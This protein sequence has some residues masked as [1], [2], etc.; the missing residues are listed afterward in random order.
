MWQTPSIQFSIHIFGAQE[1]Q[2]PVPGLDGTADPNIV[3]RT[4]VVCEVEVTITAGGAVVAMSV[5]TNS[6]LED[7]DNI[8]NIDTEC[9]SR[10]NIALGLFDKINDI[11]SDVNQAIKDRDIKKIA[12]PNLNYGKAVE[13][14]KSF[15][16]QIVSDIIPDLLTKT[17][18]R[19]I[20]RGPRAFQ[21]LLKE[22]PNKS[23]DFVS[24]AASKVERDLT[25]DPSALQSTVDDLRTEFRNIFLSTPQGL[26]TPNYTVVS[27]TDAYE[28]RSYTGYSVCSTQL[29][30]SGAT[31]SKEQEQDMLDPLN[32]GAGFN[33]L[34]SYIF[35][36]NS[37][38]EQLSMTTPVVIENGVMEFV[39]PRGT[40]AASAPAPDTVKVSLRD[41]P[42]ETL[43]VR[44][45]AGIATEG[46][47]ARQR[48]YLEDSL[49]AAGVSYDNLSFRVL[50]Y[51]PP[52]TLP[53]LRRNEVAVK[54]TYSAGLT[55][56]GTSFDA[57]LP[58][59][60]AAGFYTSRKLATELKRVS[61]I[62]AKEVQADVAVAVHV[63]VAGRGLQEKDRGRYSNAE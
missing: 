49:L 12:P 5:P 30:T 32:S 36:G 50:Q 61:L 56:A 16:R 27:K 25:Q 33:T 35:G 44:E 53:W 63:H 31:A 20:E 51:N 13:G 43:A 45:F 62:P 38:K 7:V 48:A 39:L 18:P 55:S 2:R 58:A 8:L 41:V 3:I 22:A 17:I 46:E 4:A 6:E 34:A 52:Y 54:V 29:S 47:V 11:S 37:R 57:N 60:G 24:S 59:S 42:P 40:D 26:Q 10:R 14:I 9:D 19:V 28:I 15:Q 23:R 1:K 21:D